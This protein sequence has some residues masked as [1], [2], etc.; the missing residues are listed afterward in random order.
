MDE[1]DLIRRFFAPSPRRPETI[2]GV[3]DDCAV[4]HPPAGKQL[5]ATIDTLVAGVHFLADVAPEVLGHKVLAVSLSDLAAM[6]AEPAW[7][8]LALTM[9]EAEPAWLERFSQGLLKLAGQY[10]LDL[11]GG[12]TT[13]GPLSITV[14]ALGWLPK[15]A[16][17]LRS[18]ATPGDEIYVSG[19]LG[20][21]GLGLKMLQGE[22]E[23]KAR[24]AIDR[25]QRPHPRIALGMALRGMAHACIDIS[26]GL[27]ADLGHILEA[28]GVGATLSWEALPLSEAVR[29]YI[30]E[31]GD[32]LLPLTAGDD[33]ELCFTVPEK[34]RGLLEQSL[35]CLDV[36]WHRIGKIE[37]R[38]GLRL[39]KGGEVMALPGAGYRHFCDD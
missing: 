16:A 33:Y 32:W 23:W 1:F 30:H 29:R 25:L 11:V 27:A 17:L 5:A 10:Q 14:Q 8:F 9:P 7:A 2:F 22:V 4:L 38:Q 21:A 6:G 31:S 39:N 12:D 37:R 24:E 19:C 26:D 20:D 3:G 34:S 18:A 36:S 13:R 35:Q 15:G 28:S